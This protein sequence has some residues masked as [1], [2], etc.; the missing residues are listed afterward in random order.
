MRLCI[1]MERVVFLD[2]FKFQIHKINKNN[3]DIFKVFQ[4]LD[5]CLHQ[6]GFP[7]T[8]NAGNDFYVRRSI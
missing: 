1:L 4:I 5:I 8:P 6:F 7:G 2:L 3:I